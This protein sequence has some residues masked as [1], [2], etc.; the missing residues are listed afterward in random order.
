MTRHA[1]PAFSLIELLVVI[2]IIAL[3]IGLL[4]PAL[5][6]AR[7][8]ARNLQCAV[9]LRTMGLVS[10]MYADDEKGFFPVRAVGSNPRWPSLLEGYY[11]DDD[12]LIC[13]DDPELVVDPDASLDDQ[14]RVVR[15]YFIN[16]FNDHFAADPSEFGTNVH[17]QPIAMPRKAIAEPSATFLFG[18]VLN[19]NHYY[20]DIL[21][22][23]SDTPTQVAQVR[24]FGPDSGGS[25]STGSANY[26]RADGST[27]SLRFPAYRPVNQWAVTN[28]YRD[29]DNL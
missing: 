6:A 7:A 8:T 21:D 5:G 16:G 9:N 29:P 26:A 11:S 3:L 1:R 10:N 12:V 19:K 4:L 28:T 15:S 22:G 27:K 13:P 23:V 20:C 2:S 14:S 17:N 24:H 18:E 25:A